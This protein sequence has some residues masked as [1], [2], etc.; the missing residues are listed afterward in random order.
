[1]QWIP[2]AG[3]HNVQ[4]A[5]AATAFALAIGIELDDIVQGL[6]QA[7]G[8]KGRLNFIQRQNYLFIDDTYNAN[9][10]SMRA[11]AEVLAQQAG[12]KDGDWRYW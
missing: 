6:E 9:P 8:A 4:N 11:A 2:F 7:Q 5:A 10:T 1:M 12:I 3:A